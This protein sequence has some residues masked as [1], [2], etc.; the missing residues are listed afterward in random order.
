MYSVSVPRFE[1]TSQI[2]TRISI[3]YCRILE[4]NIL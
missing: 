4:Y 3:F 2:E 1:N